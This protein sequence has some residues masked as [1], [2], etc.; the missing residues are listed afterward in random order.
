M[1]TIFL[2]LGGW[3]AYATHNAAFMQHAIY[4]F[5]LTSP[6]WGWGE[7][8]PG[9]GDT[10]SL[11]VGSIPLAGVGMALLAIAWGWTTTQETRRIILSLV[12][13]VILT[14]LML[15]GTVGLGAPLLSHLLAYPWQ[16]LGPL[17]FLLAWVSGFALR[18][19]EA[20]SPSLRLPLMASVV[21][22]T[23]LASYPYLSPRWID[24]SDLPDPLH[25]PL[26]QFGDGILLLDARYE[27]RAQPGGTLRLTLY[28]Q[29]R[30]AV[31]ADYTVFT[32]LVDAA[33]TIWA[34]KDNQPVGG[35]RPTTGWIAGEYVGDGYAIPLPASL[36]AGTYRLMVGM[37]R[38][39][40]ME[41][42]PVLSG[43]DAYLVG[44]VTIGPNTP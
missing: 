19:L 42:L 11:Q 33:G 44:E 43:G 18:G 38:L 1:L 3:N 2:A 14:L 23:V 13:A 20:L 31:E 6:L 40:T 34:Q 32:H 17:T 37:Y 15:D 28:W 9:P 27:Q 41:R 7:S 5:Q 24:A 16:L 25:G 30:R 22:I 21:A 12:V 35:T 10:L 8:I 36:P 39:D 26:A 29:T 4:P